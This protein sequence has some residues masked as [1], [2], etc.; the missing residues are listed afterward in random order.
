[1]LRPLTTYKKG[2][3]GSDLDIE[4]VSILFKMCYS[5]SKKGSVGIAITITLDAL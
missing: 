1:M 2:H 4:K 5:M 3:Y